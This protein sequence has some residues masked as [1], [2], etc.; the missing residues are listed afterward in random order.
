MVRA[1]IQVMAAADPPVGTLACRCVDS[2]DL[3]DAPI[4]VPCLGGVSSR[5]LIAAASFGIEQLRLISGDCPT[6]PDAAAEAAL[7]LALAAAEETLH[8]LHLQWIV[9]R[10]RLPECRPVAVA[11]S[12]AVSRRGLLAYVA[13]GIGQAAAEGISA[14]E[15]QRS[16][17]T[18]HKQLPPPRAHRRLLGDLMTLESRGGD[19]PVPVSD[20]LPLCDV[21]VS[22]ECDACGICLRYCPHEALSL[23]TEVPTADRGLCTG[24]GLCQEVCPRSAVRVDLAR[25]PLT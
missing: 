16:V 8:A 20:L 18:L 17:A 2:N 22:S 11:N 5:D 14:R 1:K 15:P 10:T 13:R 25:L 24:C 23:E 9:L 7:D 19:F 6:C 4:V 12:P 3:E 21:I